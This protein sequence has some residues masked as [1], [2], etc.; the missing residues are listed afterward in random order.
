M[1]CFVVLL[2]SDCPALH[3]FGIKLLMYLCQALGNIMRLSF[4]PQFQTQASIE[5]ERVNAKQSAIRTITEH[6]VFPRSDK[7][8]TGGPKIEIHLSNT[9]PAITETFSDSTCTAIIN[10]E[11]KSPMTTTFFFPDLDSEIFPRR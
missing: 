7:R 10:L 1:H 11:N 5:F 9:T 4:Q 6:S 3:S 8:R 2:L